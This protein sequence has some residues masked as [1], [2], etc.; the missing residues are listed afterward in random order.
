MKNRMAL[1]MAML[2]AAALSAA[3][4]APLLQPGDRMVFLGDSITEQRLY[5]RYV[6]NYFTLAWPGADIRFRNAGWSGDIAQ[7]GLNRLQRDV[8]SLKPTLVSVCFGM[9]DGGYRDFDPEIYS[10]YTNGM[11]CLAAELKKAGVKTVLLTPGCI[12]ADRT[13][14]AE[15]YNVTLTRF[16]KAVLEL[17]PRANLPVFDLNTLMLDVQR[18]AKADNPKFTMIPDS[19]HPSAPGQA[20]MAYALLK[21]LGCADQASA[22]TI[23][24]GNGKADPER[25]AL[26]DLKVEPDKIAFSRKDES[27]P[28]YI[29]PEARVILKYVPFENELS[30]Y[31]FAVKGLKAGNWELSVEGVKAGRFTAD[32][33]GA[34]VNLGMMPGP[35]QKIGADVNRRS[36]EQETLYFQRWR[37]CA[38][39]W[40]PPEAQ[41]EAQALQTKLDALVEAREAARL[42]AVPAERTWKWTLIRVGNAE[43]GK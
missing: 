29:D 15:A 20:V 26:S 39:G 12:D 7:G 27:L 32:Q 21:A 41:P 5:T 14:G 28:A 23:D 24:A 22:L 34:G 17:A 4:A 13:Q 33:L 6:M 3:Q 31:R 43:A 35:W 36:M 1:W 30:R 11:A 9:N 37:Q 8:L 42:A 10:H 19:I 2:P 18:R 16:A 40:V 25:C 38:L